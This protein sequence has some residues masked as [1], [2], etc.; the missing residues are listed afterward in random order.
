MKSEFEIDDLKTLG[1]AELERRAAETHKYIHALDHDASEEGIRARANLVETHNLLNL[2]RSELL[3][4][5]DLPPPVVVGMKPAYMRPRLVK[6]GYL[7]L[8]QTTPERM[9]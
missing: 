1:V 9:S 7:T 6:P 4:D 3:K 8:E 5:K 2:A